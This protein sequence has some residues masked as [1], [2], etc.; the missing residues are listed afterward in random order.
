MIAFACDTFPSWHFLAN[1]RDAYCSVGSARPAQH[2]TTASVHLT[3]RLLSIPASKGCTINPASCCLL[4]RMCLHHSACVQSPVRFEVQASSLLNSCLTL[5]TVVN[6][7]GVFSPDRKRLFP[8]AA[9]DKKMS[10]GSLG[11]LFLQR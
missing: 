5:M 3:D 7:C 6:L 9:V 8:V 1:W 4:S 2:D 10:E 11:G